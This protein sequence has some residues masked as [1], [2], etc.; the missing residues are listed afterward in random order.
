MRK[1]VLSLLLV[2]AP[3]SAQ[4]MTVSEFLGKVEGLK[5]KGPMALFSKDIGFLKK[6]VVTAGKQLRAEQVA[7]T[8]AGRKPPV[9]MPVKA[10]INSNELLGHF[11]A[12][13]A[14]QRGISVKSAF[15]GLMNKKYPCPR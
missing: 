1:Y 10:E 14:A 7:A 13:P 6:E 4:A 9:C 2:A 11:Q 15:A 5:K 12:I 8:K 3:V